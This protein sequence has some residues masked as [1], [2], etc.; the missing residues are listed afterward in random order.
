MCSGERTLP[1]IEKLTT[2][3]EHSPLG[4]GLPF[5]IER[6]DDLNIPVQHYFE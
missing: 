5:D 2:T 6:N 3:I 1:H 4:T